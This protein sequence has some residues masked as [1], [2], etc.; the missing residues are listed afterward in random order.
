MKIVKLS[1]ENVKRIKVVE[2]TPTGSLVEVT[3]AN[4]SGKTSVLDSI[5]YAL[6]TARV[7]PKQPVRRGARDATIKLDLGEIIV[8]KRINGESGKTQLV[9]ESAAGA[10][11]DSPQHMLSKLVGK[12][13]FDPLAFLG[14]DRED[15]YDTVRGLV[16][17]DVDID[18][19]DGQNQT[20]YEERT[21][22]NRSAKDL[23]AQ[24][25]GVIVPEG[26]P[27]AAVDVDA[28][29]AE[30]ENSAT[31]NATLEQRKARREQTKRDAENDRKIAVQKR[32]A[33]MEARRRADELDDQAASFDRSADE[34][35][36][37]LT[38]AGELP[39]PSD[40]SAIRQRI[41]AARATNEGIAAR[42][43]WAKLQGDAEAAERASGEL[44]QAIAARTKQKEDAI[45]AAQMPVPDLSFGEGEV[46]YRGLPLNQA[47]AAEQ[48]RISV[49]IAMAA[50]PTLRVL[51]VRQGSL[52]DEGSL[53]LLRDMAET[54]DY[55]VWL[56]RVDTSGK[57][58]IVMEDGQIK[59]AAP[60]D[61]STA[62]PAASGEPHRPNEEK[63][64]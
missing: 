12:I 10:R 16:K 38:E 51:L 26:L 53:K 31:E 17:L 39:V 49:A 2:I 7:L 20:D 5:F 63:L 3:G 32:E 37:K 22:V 23:R 36:R 13:S 61:T 21:R 35:E 57:I 44:T 29:V 42:D 59:G 19:L 33:A 45:A 6:D 40:L 27:L 47:S 48:L 52:L 41:A 62:T 60:V 18:A 55:Q 8:T 64:L 30:M 11:F 24:A 14:L 25:D 54:H 34:A 1:S 9:V 50:N 4:G 46:L 15:Q 58:G 43:R 28:L 56:E